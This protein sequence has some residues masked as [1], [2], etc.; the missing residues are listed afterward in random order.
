VCPSLVSSPTIPRSPFSLRSRRSPRVHGCGSQSRRRSS[1]G[2]APDPFHTSSR[3]VA[4]RR[5]TRL[6]NSGGGTSAWRVVGSSWTQRGEA[7][8]ATALPLTAHSSSRSSR[9]SPAGYA[10]KRRWLTGSGLSRPHSPSRRRDRWNSS[11]T[12]P[13]RLRQAAVCTAYHTSSG[14]SAAEGGATAPPGSCVPCPELESPPSA[15][16]SAERCWRQAGA[17]GGGG[18][19][20][21]TDGRDPEGG[22][23]EVPKR[24]RMDSGSM[25]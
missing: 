16:P 9:S 5:G 20:R 6:G 25:P 17:G 12:S 18:D 2:R 1:S 22:G 24:R 7:S 19:G 11:T 3:P 10:A 21:G 13:P 23:T 14:G 8:A 4:A 15:R